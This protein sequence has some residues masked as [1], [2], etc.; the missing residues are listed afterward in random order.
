MATTI[1]TDGHGIKVTDT[2]F[3]TGNSSYRIDGIINARMNLIKAAL[4]PAIT[5]ILIGIIGIVTGFLHLYSNVS[6]DAFYIGYIL[7]TANRIAIIIGAVFFITGVLW[8][9]TL[10]DK[11]AVHIVTAE[12]EKDPIVSTKKD[13][14][15]QIVTAL[16]EA[17][18]LK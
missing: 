1:Y 13:Y 16:Q 2:E 6:I 5:F 15:S 11:Y 4:A 18:R 9:V 14:V 3:Y 10:R 12:G 7:I 17:L 8:A